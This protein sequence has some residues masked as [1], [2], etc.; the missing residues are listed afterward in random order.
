[1]VTLKP[2]VA[3]RETTREFPQKNTPGRSPY[4]KETI[5]AK[6]PNVHKPGEPTPH[7]GLY[8]KVG[9]RGGK[10]GDTAVSVEGNPLPPTDKPGEGWILDVP[11]G[12]K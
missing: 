9:P 4:C 12:D 7:S 5:M 6:E 1:L 2:G 11:S 3:E 8:E 10:T